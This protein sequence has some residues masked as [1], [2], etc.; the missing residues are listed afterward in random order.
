MS[1]IQIPANKARDLQMLLAHYPYR[2]HWVAI[3][4]D[5]CE[6]GATLDR[7][8]PNKLAREGWTVHMVKRAEA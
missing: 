8:Q 2:L 5:E 7:R 4:G 3:K 1:E 6:V